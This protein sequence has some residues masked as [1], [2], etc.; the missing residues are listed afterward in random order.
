MNF[1]KVSVTKNCLRL[2]TAALT[3]LAMKKF[4]RGQKKSHF[5]STNFC[6]SAFSKYFA[7]TN[8]RESAILRF[9]HS[10]MFYKI[11]VY[12]IHRKS[13]APVKFLK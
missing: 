10:Q 7:Y 1:Q 11:G 12:K 6:E 2:E 9:F 8:F 5:M 3:I 4:S 13:P